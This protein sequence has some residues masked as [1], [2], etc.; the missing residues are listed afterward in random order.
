MA[1][2]KREATTTAEALAKEVESLT[3]K[4]TA[5]ANLEAELTEA[6]AHIEKTTQSHSQQLA[7]Y[8]HGITDGEDVADIMAIYERR[9]P[10][11]VDLS[12]WLSSETLP[13]SV[14][15]L[16]AKTP[17]TPPASLEAPANPAPE[18]ATAPAPAVES[19]PATPSPGQAVPTANAGAVATGP[20]PAMPS[21]QEISAMSTEQYKAHRDVLLASLTQRG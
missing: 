12:A 11:G 16:M 13:R 9:A 19:P 17:P 3:A 5:A 10:A 14:A 18:T 4:A 20:A 2:A 8:K 21:P 1:K 7:V 15:A 6:R